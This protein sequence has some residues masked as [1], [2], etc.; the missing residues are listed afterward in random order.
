MDSLRIEKG[1]RAWGTDIIDQDSPIEAGLGF[2]VDF[3]KANFIGKSALLKQRGKIINKR[4]VIFRLDDP[5]VLLLGE[6]AK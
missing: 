4:L 5:D 2:A 3:S 6:Q 1:Y